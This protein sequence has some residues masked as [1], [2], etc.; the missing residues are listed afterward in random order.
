VAVFVEGE[1]IGYIPSYAAKALPFKAGSSIAVPLQLFCADLD[2]GLRVEAF[3]WLGNDKPQ[4]QFSTESPPAMS[5][6]QKRMAA[7]A[8]SS[9]MVHDALAQ[10]GVRAAQFRAGV[11]NGVHYLE[12]VEPIKQL[13]REGKLEEALVMSYAATEAAENG[14]EGREPPP[15]YTEQA[16]IIHRKLGQ[17]DQ[18][19]A[20]L[21]RW[22]KFMPADKRNQTDL[23]ERLAK[24]T[25]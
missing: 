2:A 22:L 23:G 13:K 25:A 5:P 4:W 16:A 21:S 9:E 12:L 3:L 8:S 10:G 17:K 15:W 14:R 11:V 1:R 20:V 6:E 18:E 7:Q 19:I 24:I